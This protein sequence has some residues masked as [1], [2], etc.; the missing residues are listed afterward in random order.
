VTIIV[1]GNGVIMS[2]SGNLLTDSQSAS[3]DKINDIFTIFFLVEYCIKVIGLGIT[4]YYTDSMNWL[5]FIIVVFGMIDYELS[6]YIER[7]SETLDNNH[8]L[9]LQKKFNILNIVRIFRSLRLLKIL[10]KLKT[11]K[12]ILNG[13]IATLGNVLYLLALIGMFVLIYMLLG[14]ALMNQ[15]QNFKSLLGAFYLVFT[16]TT[17]ENWNSYLYALF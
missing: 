8:K 9:Q 3:V 11:M 4:T 14:I 12:K 1:I 16:I 17:V 6:R 15:D 10:R 5:D 7:I 2:L 13:V